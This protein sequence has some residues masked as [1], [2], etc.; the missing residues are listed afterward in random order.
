MLAL[1]T[2]ILIHQ[3]SFPSFLFFVNHRCPA[4]AV[5]KVLGAPKQ[6]ILH[7]SYVKKRTATFWLEV[8][9]VPKGKHPKMK[10]AFKR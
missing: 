7:E 9:C 6:L 2:P 4:C 8:R 3:R 10:I 5:E 1:I